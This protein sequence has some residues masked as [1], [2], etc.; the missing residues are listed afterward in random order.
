MKGLK[1]WQLIYKLS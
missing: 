1:R